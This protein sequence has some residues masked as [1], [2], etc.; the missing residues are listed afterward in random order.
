MTMRSID[1]RR[2]KELLAAHD[3]TRKHRD[4]RADELFCISVSDLHEQ[5]EW[6]GVSSAVGDEVMSNVEHEIADPEHPRFDPVL[7]LSIQGDYVGA[8]NTYLEKRLRQIGHEDVVVSGD[9]ERLESC[10]CCGRRT[11]NGRG[12][13]EICRVCWWEDDGHDN[14]HASDVFGGPNGNVSLTQGR[15]NFLRHGLFNPQRHD[16]IPLADA[17]EKY[18]LGRT[19]RSMKIVR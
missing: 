15:M 16:L 9:V 4:W 6:H 13:Y 19:F 1:R 10:P 12:D 8:T 14:A 3:L 18:E 2:A 5:A 17:P 11:L 7:L